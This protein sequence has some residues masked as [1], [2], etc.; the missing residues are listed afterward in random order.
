[1]AEGKGLSKDDRIRNREMVKQQMAEDPS[2]LFWL[3]FSGK[4]GYDVAKLLRD[5][6]RDYNRLLRSA[7]YGIPID[8]TKAFQDELRG[9][10]ARIWDLVTAFIPKLHTVPLE[11]VHTL[12]NDLSERRQKAK[13]FASIC[14]LPRST[15]TAYLGMAV[16]QIEETGATLQGADLDALDKLIRGCYDQVKEDLDK[17]QAKL[18]A[19][20][21]PFQKRGPVKKVEQS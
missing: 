9:D 7:G 19:M 20:V 8:K 14:F 17:I 12:N 5:I 15:E 4:H 2:A 3:P 1:M 11:R 6:D 18:N 13:I 21:P 16:K 10:C